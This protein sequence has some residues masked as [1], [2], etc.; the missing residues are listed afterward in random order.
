[1][2]F[3]ASSAC[4]G[5]GL[6]IDLLCASALDGLFVYATLSLRHDDVVLGLRGESGKPFASSINGLG[7]YSCVYVFWLALH[8]ESSLLH[9]A[10]V[11]PAVLFAF[12]CDFIVAPFFQALF[13]YRAGKGSAVPFALWGRGH[14]DVHRFLVFLRGRRAFRRP[15]LPQLPVLS[16]LPSLFLPTAAL[17]RLRGL[18]PCP[19]AFMFGCAA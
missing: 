2:V 8:G 9:L 19:P 6:V 14:I 5:G 17:P 3:S 1:M 15:R 11:G 12:G 10:A 13:F 18:S 4:G 16:F 7:M